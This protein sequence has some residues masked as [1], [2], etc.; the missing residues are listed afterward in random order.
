MK[1][2]LGSLELEVHKK[3]ERPVWVRVHNRLNPKQIRI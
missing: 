3:A 2:K 1:L